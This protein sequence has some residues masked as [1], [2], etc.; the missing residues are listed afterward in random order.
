MAERARQFLQ[1]WT[2]HRESSPIGHDEAEAIAEEWEVDA[3]ENGISSE[4]LH[5]AAGGRLTDYLL[6]TFGDGTI[7]LLGRLSAVVNTGG[8]KVY[9]EEVEEALKAHPSV[10][11]A[12][13][14]GLPD[15]R[16]GEAITALVEPNPGE[17]IDEAEL[18]RHVKDNLAAY[19]APK[20]V[21]QIDTIGRAA[22]GKLDYRRLKADAASRM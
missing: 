10:F 9:P 14:V 1:E 11:D 7:D 8:E 21:F 20:R 22:N 12:A 18:I 15:E 6:R 2:L 3:A 13:V 16:F 19:K 4:D 17:T 5:K